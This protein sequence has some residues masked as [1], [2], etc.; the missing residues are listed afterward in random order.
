MDIRQ[1]EAVDAVV[2][3][4]TITKAAEN[5]NISQ[6]A[7][8]T[9]IKK[10]E[11]ECGFKIFKRR[12]SGVDLTAEGEYFYRFILPV[13]S[14]YNVAL[15]KIR[16]IKKRGSEIR[17]G[18]SIGAFHTIDYKKGNAL[19][20]RFREAYPKERFTSYEYPDKIIDEML[21]KGE[22]DCALTLKPT[23]EGLMY[24]KILDVRMSVYMS[25]EHRLSKRKRL[26]LI[27]LSNEKFAMVTKDMQFHDLT[28]EHCNKAGFI[29]DVVFV[30]SDI[31]S[32]IAKLKRGD[33]I[34]LGMDNIPAEDGITK[35][36]LEEPDFYWTLCMVYTKDV[37]HNKKQSKIL[38][39][40]SDFLK[41][42]IGKQI[43]R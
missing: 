36:Y 33:C 38:R 37:L 17:L 7:L 35:V 13:I 23:K 18:V 41:E 21:R 22:L 27:D 12:P 34:F 5:I 43:L 20:D 24:N 14:E 42:S 28:I 3:Y 15:N 11:D 19:L 2:K 26:K 6:Q 30:A 1:F 32:I 25:N 9:T 10:L 29:P 4:G 40:M 39:C 16:Q 31:F 8:S